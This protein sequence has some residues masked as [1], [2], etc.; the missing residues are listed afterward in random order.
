[1]YEEALF[2]AFEMNSAPLLNQIRILAHKQKNLFV[3]SVIDYHKEKESPGSSATTLLKS[4]VQIANFSKKQLKKEDFSNLYKDF[5]TLLRIDD[6]S[7]LELSDFNTWDLNLDAYQQALDLEFE[8]KFE[9]AMKI[10]EE[11]GLNNDVFRVKSI[12]GELN[13]ELREGERHLI[14]EDIRKFIGR[15]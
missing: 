2:L 13:K 10:Y 4:L 1:M 12:I 9:E 8:G 3:E 7:D 11:N 15:E 14:F 6:I 5:D